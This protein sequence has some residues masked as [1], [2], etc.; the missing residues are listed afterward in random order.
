MPRATNLQARTRSGRPPCTGPVLEVLEAQRGRLPERDADARFSP[1]WPA[2][3]TQ[4]RLLFA[5]QMTRMPFVTLN[6]RPV[7]NVKFGSR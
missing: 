5:Y 3:A 7:Q 2:N 1:P 6:P 4:T